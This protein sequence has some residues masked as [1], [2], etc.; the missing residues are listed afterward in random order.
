MIV[1]N[2]NN[3]RYLLYHCNSCTVWLVKKLALKKWSFIVDQSQYTYLRAFR[4][5]TLFKFYIQQMY[6]LLEIRQS[7]GSWFDLIELH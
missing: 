1:D 2:Q 5:D 6:T 4:S 3:G 7:S